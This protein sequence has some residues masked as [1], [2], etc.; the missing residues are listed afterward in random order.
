MFVK[1]I[2][3]NMR[4]RFFLGHS[5]QHALQVTGTHTLTHKQRAVQRQTSDAHHM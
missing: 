3:H 2:D 1:V 4:V 5:V